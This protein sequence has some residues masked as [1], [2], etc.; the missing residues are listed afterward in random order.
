MEKDPLL[1]IIIPTKNRQYTAVFAVQSV[2]SIVSNEIEVIVQ[3]CSDNDSLNR[4]LSDKFGL[5]HRL[6]YFHTTEKPSLTE[7]WNL[8][9]SNTTG[10]YIC[11]IG[12]DDAV[13]PYCIEVA[14][15]MDKK[16][17]QA[18]LGANVNYIWKDAYKGSFSSGRLTHELYYSGVFFEVDIKKEFTKKM[19]NCGFGYTDDIPNLYHGIIEKSLLET[20]KSNCGHYLSSTS[21]DVYTAMILPSYL[22][23]SYYLDF[24]ITV[25]GAS[26]LS[27]ANRIY[28]KKKYHIHFG[29]FSNLQIP[30]ILPKTLTCEV[31]IAESTIIA[32]QDTKKEN[33]ISKM[34]LAIVY[35]KCAALDLK[36]IISYTEQYKKNRNATN[37][38]NDFYLYLI[39]FLK[40]RCKSSLKDL[41]LK[42]L[43]KTVPISFRYIEKFA[44][45]K[46]V[47]AEDILAA[48][49]L[50]LDHIKLNSFTIKFE[51]DPKI[52]ISKKTL[53][54]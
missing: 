21:F 27:N 8:A 25:K 43:Y 19:L 1:S 34:N 22:E 5:N 18:V 48:N 41:I 12:D 17:I 38:N 45:K 54:D 26:G 37:S 33:L 47:L 11:G 9:I 20:H 10:K 16:N 30:D 39:K 36:N 3:D 4:L 35:G 28:S 53:W 14:K 52:L 42:I 32:L 29:E 31:S 44:S 46:K 50:L 24:P 6:K 7:N 40:D 15:W 13:L 23:K 49:K 2:L 51:D